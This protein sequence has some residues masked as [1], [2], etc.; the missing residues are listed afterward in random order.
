MFDE[1]KKA[2]EIVETPEPVVVK[3]LEDKELEEVA[4]GV[5]EALN[6]AEDVNCHNTQCC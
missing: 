2:E 4:G 6:P 5:A 1:K 3:E